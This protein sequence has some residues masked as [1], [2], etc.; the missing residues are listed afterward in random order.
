MLGMIFG[1]Y[2]ISSN[3]YGRKK[4]ATKM[5]AF[6]NRSRIRFAICGKYFIRPDRDF[7]ECANNV[8][9]VIIMSNFC[10]GCAKSLRSR[11]I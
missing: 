8:E 6:E 7:I 3:S 2:I 10:K 1:R 11:G 9:H 5:H 4:P